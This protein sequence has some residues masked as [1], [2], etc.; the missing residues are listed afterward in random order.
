MHFQA[1]QDHYAFSKKG[2]LIAANDVA[3]IIIPLSLAKVKKKLDIAHSLTAKLNKFSQEM[4]DMHMGSIY[5]QMLSSIA[6]TRLEFANNKFET[7]SFHLAQTRQFKHSIVFDQLAKRH[8]ENKLDTWFPSNAIQFP[9]SRNGLPN[10]DGLDRRSLE[11]KDD[12][13]E[14]PSKSVEVTSSAEITA[15]PPIT[16]PQAPNPIPT[17]K[18]PGVMDLSKLAGIVEEEEDPA[19]GSEPASEETNANTRDTQPAIEASQPASQDP[20][21]PQIPT[22][23]VNDSVDP[24]DEDFLNIYSD[25]YL[26]SQ[27]NFN[28]RSVTGSVNQDLDETLSRDKRQIVIGM[29]TALLTSI[30]VSSAFGAIDANQINVIKQEVSGI[31]QKQKLIIH[32]LSLDS[33]NI[34]LNRHHLNNLEQL[35][36]KIGKLVT[37][38]HYEQHGMLVYVLMT[39]EFDRIEH[40]LNHFVAVLEAAT[41][42]NFYL[43][44]LTQNGATEVFEQIKGLSEQKGLTPIISSPQQLSQMETT[45]YFAPHGISLI[46]EVPLVSDSNTFELYEFKA[47]PI[48]LGSEAF[49]KIEPAEKYLAIGEPDGMK[50][51]AQYIELSL[52]DLEKCRKLGSVRLC[53]DLRV[54]RR[55]QNPSC[56]YSLWILDHQSA[57]D[58][59]VITAH[60]NNE[61]QVA[62]LGN[63]LFAYY[64]A[65]PSTYQYVCTNNSMSIGPPQIHG[66]AEIKVPKDCFVQ[67]SS[68]KLHR[69]NSISVKAPP[70]LRR[71]TLPVMSFLENQTQVQDVMH[72]LDVLE[73]TKGLPKVD[74]STIKK[75][76]DMNKPYYY[77]PVPTITFVLATLAFMLVSI[78]LA[79]FLFKNYRRNRDAR[80]AKDPEVRFRSLLQD[81]ANLDYLETLLAKRTET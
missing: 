33:H 29:V 25:Q 30:G 21:A 23:A 26:N 24:L 50:G 48:K 74:Q 59:C 52:M 80:R 47:I 58:S 9:G 3:N 67:T 12:N 20:I 4:R 75:L 28:K 70:K 8:Q 34:M 63:D 6:N 42:K 78:F 56:L 81:E 35:T 16:G 2:H 39:A 36:L 19:T 10:F 44:T 77:R 38:Q 69:Q 1:F 37:K 41:N 65:A 22:P 71:W 79:Y 31:G 13:S 49:V 72:A 32:E 53:P 62:P 7:I 45:Y 66:V 40:E 68:F 5:V 57:K 76:K 14:A 11:T 73:H 17:T 61:D 46:V 54:I 27:G 64:S 51:Y 18:P 60:S 43:G 15:A 55:P